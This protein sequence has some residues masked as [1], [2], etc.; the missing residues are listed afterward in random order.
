MAGLTAP[1]CPWVSLI[2]LPISGPVRGCHPAQQPLPLLG[3]ALPLVSPVCELQETSLVSACLCDSAECNAP[4]RTRPRLARRPKKII[5]PTET[6]QSP[7]RLGRQSEGLKCFSCGSLFNRSSPACSKVIHWKYFHENFLF[8]SQFD[9]EDPS[10]VSRCEP[11]Q[12]CLLYAW[13]KSSTEIGSYR[14]Q[15]WFSPSVTNGRGS[16]LNIICHEEHQLTFN[17]Q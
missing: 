15:V 3:P 9:P 13:K 14:Y 17:Q 2:I 6:S 4:D 1:D 7:G 16:V 11:G 8:S 10:Q 12:A 5:F